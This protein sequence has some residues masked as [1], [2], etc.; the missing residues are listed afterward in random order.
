MSVCVC[1]CV[2]QVCLLILSSRSVIESGDMFIRV[3]MTLDTACQLDIRDMIT[4]LLEP[5]HPI[6]DADVTQ[7]LTMP[8]GMSVC[9]SAC[10]SDMITGLLEPGHPITDADVTQLLTMPRGMSVSLSASVYL[11]QSIYLSVCLSV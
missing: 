7:L 11:S 1:V 5:G 3:A 8:R 10:L 2:C 9:L 6:T 4:G